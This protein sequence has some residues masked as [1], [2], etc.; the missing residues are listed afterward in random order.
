MFRHFV[1]TLLLRVNTITGV[2]YRQVPGASWGGTAW[3]GCCLQAASRRR[4]LGRALPGVHC[5][6]S[7]LQGVHYLG[8]Q[9]G[10][11]AGRSPLPARSNDPTIMSWGLANEPQCHGD[12]TACV[13][14][15][16][17]DSTAAF[18]RALA[19]DQL[20]TLDCEGF[21]GPAAKGKR[22]LPCRRQLPRRVHRL[23]V[24]G[25][26]CESR[27]CCYIVPQRARQPLQRARRLPCWPK[28]RPPPPRPSPLS[29]SLKRRKREQP[30]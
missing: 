27:G 1:S 16:W 14:S 17:A 6:L 20:I 8:V 26:C 7:A 2:M 28:L 18:V 9:A 5:C 23:S 29:L 12:A 11:M 4:C 21:I 24:H 13:I 22:R 30:F 25:T 19:P 3:R 10:D 15:R